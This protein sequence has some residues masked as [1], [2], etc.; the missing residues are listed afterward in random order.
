[1]NMVSYL[2]IDPPFGCKAPKNRSKGKLDKM[3]KLK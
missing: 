1:M 3:L 2:L